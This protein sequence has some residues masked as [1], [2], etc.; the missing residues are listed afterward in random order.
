MLKEV[1][2]NFIEN[3]IIEIDNESFSLIEDSTLKKNKKKQ[4]LE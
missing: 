4:E 2:L 3:D 1:V